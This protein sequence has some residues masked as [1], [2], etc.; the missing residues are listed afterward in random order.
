MRF[1]KPAAAVV[2]ATAVLGGCLA[3]PPVK[4][5]DAGATP[6]EDTAQL[7]V[8]AA[9]RASK[10]EVLEMLGGPDVE[11]ASGSV[12]VYRELSNEEW[13]YFFGAMP[14]GAGLG[15]FEGGR[16]EKDIP[17]FLILKFDSDSRVASW[18]VETL[19]DEY[20]S[21]PVRCDDTACAWWFRATEADGTPTWEFTGIYSLFADKASVFDA[22]GLVSSPG[23]CR[24]Y[25]YS[26]SPFPV[27]SWLDGQPAGWLLDK[28]QLLYW[29]LE[30]G[31]HRL[32]AQLVIPQTHRVLGDK[33]FG[34]RWQSFECVAG[35]SYFFEARSDRGWL[36]D[37]RFSPIELRQR[38]KDEGRKAVRKRKPILSTWDRSGAVQP[39]VRNPDIRLDFV[40]PGK[41]T[42]ADLAAVLGPPTAML[43][44]MRTVAYIIA[45]PS[46]FEVLGVSNGLQLIDRQYVIFLF[47]EGNGVVTGYELRSTSRILNW[48]TIFRTAGVRDDGHDISAP[49]CTLSGYCF[50]PGGFVTRYASSAQQ[51]SSRRDRRRINE[52]V[53]N[54]FDYYPNVMWRLFIDGEF[55]AYLGHQ[56]WPRGYLR[57]VIDGGEHT[58]TAQIVTSVE[59]PLPFDDKSGASTSSETVKLDCR[60]Y[61]SYDVA[62]YV[63]DGRPDLRVRDDDAYKSLI[64]RRKL[65]LSE[66]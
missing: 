22:N 61:R 11:F 63:E 59:D 3:I 48:S 20:L 27:E 47:T 2:V 12:W 49:N 18:Q 35:E 39:D 25:L 43:D 51:K 33:I 17:S 31:E 26:K 21:Q 64:R 23:S 29:D 57:S 46:W 28:K 66:N 56:H 1:I 37:I 36:D 42:L 53:V 58:L 34:R 50:A 6:Y 30:S 45:G 8:L 38:S 14:S 24:A 65:I 16:Y 19:G 10:Y 5:E 13:F 40:D 44:D 62:L 55:A 41:T 4:L 9:E 7:D 60:G 54:A 52:C 15:G 32:F